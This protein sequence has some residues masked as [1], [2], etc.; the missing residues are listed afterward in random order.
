MPSRAVPLRQPYRR[1][2][3]IATAVEPPA[4]TTAWHC[5][6]AQAATKIHTIAFIG[7]RHGHIGSVFE[8]ASKSPHLQITGVCEEDAATREELK[9]K[10]AF[11]HTSYDG[12]LDE[13]QAATPTRAAL[14][15]LGLLRPRHCECCS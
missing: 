7:F 14:L 4:A 3:R 13:V 10:Y 11:T 12:M 6:S 15:G 2:H 1:L 9:E 8:A 5:A